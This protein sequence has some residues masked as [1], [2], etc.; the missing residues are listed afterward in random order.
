MVFK[1]QY[2]IIYLS[3]SA[4]M[5]ASANCGPPDLSLLDCISRS[6]GLRDVSSWY[7]IHVVGV[8]LRCLETL[9]LGSKLVLYMSLET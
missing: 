6:P 2:K 4:G 3:V 7:S 9:G 5:L 1:A 8:S